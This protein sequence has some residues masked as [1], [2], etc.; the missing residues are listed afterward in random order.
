MSTEKTFNIKP[1]SVQEPLYSD[2]LVTDS[3]KCEAARRTGSSKYTIGCI[4]MGIVVFFMGSLAWGAL[5]A[6][7]PASGVPLSFLTFGL[8]I[9]L[10][11]LVTKVMRS[12]AL[13]ENTRRVVM[14]RLEAASLREQSRENET[15][16]ATAGELVRI[17]RDQ[18]DNLTSLHTLLNQGD[19]ILDEADQ[20]FV[21]RAYTPFWD[22]TEQALEQLRAF[23]DRV[24]LIS[25]SAR[26]YYQLLEGREHTFPPFPVN[27]EDIPA[28]YALVQRL[29][30]AIAPAHR[31]FQ[32]ASIYEQ[33]K[34]SNAIIAGF[35][36]MQEA[37]ARLRHD[38]VNS[39]DDLQQSL[40]SG[41]AAIRSA[42]E[43]TG[44][45]QQEALAQLQET[46]DAH[47]GATREKDEQDAKHR[48]FVKEALDNIQHRRKPRP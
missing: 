23:N 27:T 30:K 44:E 33:R 6:A 10:P 25:I 42:I 14:E 32:F 19:A 9:A 28:P 20:L 41:L 38:I 8:A 24:K 21:E 36:N 3:D 37:I 12:V 31:D 39:I 15:A 46:L 7:N 11:L 16:S 17:Y 35:R 29:S 22:A 5:V 4:G 48:E 26:Q 45:Q 18:P 47:A 34:T 40:G 2:H 43:T 13:T 1:K